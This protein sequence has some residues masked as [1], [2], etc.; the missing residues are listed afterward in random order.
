MVVCDSVAG[1]GKYRLNKMRTT[2]HKQ[3]P[4]SPLAKCFC[5]FFMLRHLLYYM[6]SSIKLEM[7]ENVFDLEKKYLNNKKLFYKTKV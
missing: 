3:F 6:F 5:K 7:F 2:S 4:H 1:F